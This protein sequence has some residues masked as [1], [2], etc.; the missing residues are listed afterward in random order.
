MHPA[1]ES[2]RPR[3]L[4]A[5][6]AWLWQASAADVDALASAQPDWRLEYQQLSAGRFRGTVLHAQLPG[7]RLVREEADRSMRQRGELGRGA[8]GFALPLASSGAARFDGRPVPRD[9]IMVGRSDALDLCTPDGFAL[10]AVVADAALLQPPWWRSGGPA[11]PGP[12]RQAV[13]PVA[14]AAADALRAQHLRALAALCDPASPLHDARALLQLRDALL[15]EWLEALPDRIDAPELPTVAA[16]KRLVDAACERMLA[17]PDAPPSML[18][19]CRHVGASRRTL[20]Y[21]F[22][23]VLGTSPVRYLRAVRLAG[24]RRELRA[25]RG[26]VQDV[27]ARWGFWHPSQFAAD[28]RR[29]FGETPST[30]LRGAGGGLPAGA[31]GGSAAGAPAR[32]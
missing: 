1:P 2:A 3:P 7:L 24:V 26:P 4:A 32:G 17:R 6:G 16:R 27:A 25:G 29:Q 9:A 30:T 13:V 28:Y 22:Q 31:G 19:V 20:N 14:A 11:A 18:E 5:P 23:H 21:A 12:D 8:V 15:I 10:V